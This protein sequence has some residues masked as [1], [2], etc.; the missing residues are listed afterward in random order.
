MEQQPLATAEPVQPPIPKWAYAVV[1]PT[2]KLILRSPLHG[3]LS[4]ALMVL[5]FEGRK[6][7]RRYEIPVGYQEEG[8]KLYTFSHSAWG[9]N[10]AGGAPVA[11]RLRGDLVR[12]TAR[13]VHDP[14][15]TAQLI[16]RM[17]SERG[18]QMAERMGLL[19][20]GPDGA[21]RPQLPRGSRLIE[22]TLE[23]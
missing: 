12:A 13:V 9:K 7:G 17:A 15:L 23:R 1:N 21:A 4:G 2:M 19:G 6:S 5:M 16:E 20:R 11:L 18:A 8:G 22:F 3:G 10:F 14:A